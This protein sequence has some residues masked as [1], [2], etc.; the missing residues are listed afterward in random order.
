MEKPSSNLQVALSMMVGTIVFLV[1]SLV[2]VLTGLVSSSM[3]TLTA[4]IVLAVMIV[5]YFTFLPLL[6]W[7][8][9]AGYTGAIVLA[10]IASLSTL[11]GV[12]EALTGIIPIEFALADTIGL[13][14]SIILI[15]SSVAAWRERT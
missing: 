2:I 13:I 15:A 12:Y 3:G 14:M 5:L 8:N 9:K 1:A 11:Y 10:I 6:W 7:R 4:T